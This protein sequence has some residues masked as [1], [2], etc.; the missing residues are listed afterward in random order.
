MDLMD[1]EARPGFNTAFFV[2]IFSFQNKESQLAQ[3]FTLQQAN[4]PAC[5]QLCQLAADG[6]AELRYCVCLSAIVGRNC[7]IR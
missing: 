2:Q 1:P 4:N 5:A 7:N 6:R 3:D